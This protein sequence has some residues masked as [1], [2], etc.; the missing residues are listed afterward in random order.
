M[1]ALAILCLLGSAGSGLAAA[2]VWWLA[3][4]HPT[5][6]QTALVPTFVVLII[7]VPCLFVLAVALAIASFFV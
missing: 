4:T 6:S 1:L 5:P 2:I 7:A 3:E